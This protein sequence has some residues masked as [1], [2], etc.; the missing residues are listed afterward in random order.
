[1]AGPTPPR[2]PSL[3]AKYEITQVIP[4]DVSTYLFTA[5]QIAHTRCF[6]SGKYLVVGLANDKDYAD[7]LTPAMTNKLRTMGLQLSESSK[8][9]SER[10]IVARRVDSYLLEKS[11]DALRTEIERR[12]D[13]TVQEV[14]VLPRPHL[15][16]IRLATLDDFNKLKSNGIKVLSR[17]IPRYDLETERYTEVTQCYK[18]LQFSHRTNQCTATEET[19]S[20]CAEKGHSFKTCTSNTIKCCNCGGDHP[21]VAFKCIAKKSAIEQQNR[22]TTPP[23]TA[24]GTYAAAAAPPQ[25]TPLLTPAANPVLEAKQLKIQACLQFAIAV[26]NGDAVTFA[27]TYNE[28]LISNNLPAITIPD[29][30]IQKAQNT[31]QAKT[32][33]QNAAAD[34]APDTPHVTAT[35]VTQQQTTQSSDPQSHSRPKSPATNND[36]HQHATPPQHPALPHNNA[37]LLPTPSTSSFPLPSILPSTQEHDSL[38]QT[39]HAPPPTHPYH[40]RQTSSSSRDPRLQANRS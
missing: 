26:A 1:M 31:L 40:T 14:K 13:V 39:T 33:Q 25:P 35:T 18:C 30:V 36:S 38:Y 10:T 6:R 12:N 3:T 19:C 4:D 7:H 15:M 28:L 17:I 5:T 8:T 2:P 24:H 34:P 27:N 22:K 11:P 21:A 29:T 37:T 32:A 20:K 9:L 16:K 23:T